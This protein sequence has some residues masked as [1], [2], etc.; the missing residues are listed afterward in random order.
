MYLDGLTP[1]QGGI[2]AN[3]TIDTSISEVQGSKFGDKVY[4]EGEVTLYLEE[5]D[6]FAQVTG[7]RNVVITGPGSDI[8][9]ITEG[10][11]LHWKDIDSE[12][13]VDLTLVPNVYNLSHL[14]YEYSHR[15]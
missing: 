5:G 11:D 4:T 8:V 6:D 10:A 12:D 9:Q 15:K 3:H 7:Q 14:I 13:T 1:G 2:A